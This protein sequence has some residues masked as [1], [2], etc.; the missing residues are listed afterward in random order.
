MLTDLQLRNCEENEFHNLAEAKEEDLSP[1]V[2]ILA[3]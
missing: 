1:N 3:N 2:S